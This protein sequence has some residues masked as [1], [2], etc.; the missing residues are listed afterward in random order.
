MLCLGLEPW[1]SNRSSRFRV[2]FDLAALFSEVF[3][4]LDRLEC[5]NSDRSSDHGVFWADEFLPYGFFPYGFLPNGF[6]PNEFL[7][8]VSP[9]DFVP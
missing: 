8:R 2:R 7:P 5:L 6:L 3:D 1:C 9:N 4:L